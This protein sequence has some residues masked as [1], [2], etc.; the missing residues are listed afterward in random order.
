MLSSK[1]LRAHIYHDSHQMLEIYNI[2][3]SSEEV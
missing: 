3:K 1:L 2:I